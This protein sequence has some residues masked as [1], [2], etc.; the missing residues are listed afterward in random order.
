MI[1]LD[2]EINIPGV[3]TLYPRPVLESGG[4]TMSILLIL[5]LKLSIKNK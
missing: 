1:E 5:L 4:V 3:T 2:Q